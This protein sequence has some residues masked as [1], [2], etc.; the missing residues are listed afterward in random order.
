M[1]KNIIII[2]LLNV[3]GFSINV[4]AQCTCDQTRLANI[5]SNA[6][7]RLLNTSNQVVTSVSPGTTYYLRVRATT[8]YCEL[9]GSGCSGINA[10]VTFQVKL[11]DGAL[12]G[13]GNP[14]PP[15]IA[16]DVGTSNN[17][18]AIFQIQTLT[19]DDFSDVIYFRIGAQCFPSPS[20][21]LLSSSLSSDRQVLLP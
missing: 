9:S 11:A 6:E 14:I 4:S 21:G 16:Q 3:M 12:S 17:Y 5:L 19:G 15:A 2:L 10:P 8:G 7:V 13:F 18:T 1:K 20:C